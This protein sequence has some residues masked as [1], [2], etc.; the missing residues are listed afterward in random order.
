MKLEGSQ[1]PR[2]TLGL[3]MPVEGERWEMIS[4]VKHW[5]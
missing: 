1:A 5:V 3:K 4:S 2:N